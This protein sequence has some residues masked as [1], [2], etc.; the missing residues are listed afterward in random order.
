MQ[1]LIFD[2]YNEDLIVSVINIIFSLCP[3]KKKQRIEVFEVSVTVHISLLY[4]GHIYF[5]QHQ[6]FSRDKMKKTVKI[7]IESV[8]SSVR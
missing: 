7:G 1:V 4:F 6:L 2:L 5:L 8:R 3:S